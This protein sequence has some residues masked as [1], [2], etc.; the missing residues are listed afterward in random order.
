MTAMAK[1]R[2]LVVEDE[3]L[4]GR[5]IHNMLRSLGYDV[6]DVVSRGEDAVRIAEAEHPDLILM[7]IVLKGEMDG[8]TAAEQIW[9]HGHSGVPIIYLTAYADEST[10]ARAKL[11]EP[12]GYILKPFD[13]RELRTAVEMAF[14]KAR[15]DSKLRDREEWLATILKS[16]GDGVIATDF[17]GRISFLNPLA[18]RL[19][20]WTQDAALDRPAEEV[21]DIVGDGDADYMTPPGTVHESVLRKRTGQIVPIEKSVTMIRPGNRAAIGRVYIF[22][23]IT[24]RKEADAELKDSRD[25]LEK[26]LAGTVQAMSRTIELRDPYTAGHQ[27]RVGR[28]SDAIARELGLPFAQVEGVRMSG[29]IHDIGKIYV[30]AEI[31]SKPGHITEVEYS[32]IRNHAQA[33]YEILKTIDFPWPIAEIVHQHHE[34]LDGSGYPAGLTRDQI[35]LEAKIISVADVVEA[36]SSHRPYRPAHGIDAALAEIEMFRGKRFDES[37]VDACLR[38][39]REKRFVFEP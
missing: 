38:L 39:F 16:I 35:L 20:G 14:Y 7:D 15:M 31:L 36:M 29:D 18:E 13:E 5:D 1:M 8:I 12:F 19:T 23:D 10:L 27:R 2:I 25:R 9:D 17:A 24:R 6:I 28:L 30:P 22:R 37:V 33:G 34:R 3:S 4:V 21:L 11:T 26:A 32:I